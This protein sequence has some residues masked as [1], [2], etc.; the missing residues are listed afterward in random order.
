MRVAYIEHVLFLLYING[1]LNSLS[2]DA[3]I[4]GD[5]LNI[6]WPIEYK[7]GFQRLQ[8]IIHRLSNW[9]KV[10]LVRFNTDRCVVLRLYF[11]ITKNSYVQCQLSGECE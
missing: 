7:N 5:D 4:S 8:N 1:Y 6:W 2:C 10:A 3:A 11:R 9:F